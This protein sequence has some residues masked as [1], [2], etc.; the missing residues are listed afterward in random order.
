MYTFN[1]RSDA[2]AA[3]SYLQLSG[4]YWLIANAHDAHMLLAMQHDQHGYQCMCS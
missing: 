4:P 2:H 3:V 1:A